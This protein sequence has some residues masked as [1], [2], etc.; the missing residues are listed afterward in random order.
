MTAVVVSNLLWYGNRPRELFFPERWDVEVLEPPGFRKAAI[1]EKEISRAFNEPIG[2]KPLADLASGA[3]EVVIGFDDITRPTPVRTVLPFVLSE[4]ALAG[5]RTDSIRFIPALG[6]HGAMTNIEFRKKLGDDVVRNYP[7]Y[8]HNPYENCDYLGDSTSG[9]P[10]YINREFMSCELKI[11]IGCI[12]PHV[13]AGFGGGGKL[14]LPGLAGHQTIKFFHGDLMQRDIGS[15]GLGKFEGNVMVDAIQEVVRMSGLDIKIDTL[16]NA[17]GEITD[18]FVGDPVEACK[19][20]VEVAKGHY[21]TRM[22]PNKD[23]V[24]VNAYAKYNEMAICMMMALSTANLAGSTIVLLVDAPEGQ[25]CHYLMRSFG[26]E[27]GGCEYAKRGPLPESLKVIVCSA[28]PDKTMC[29]LFAP[30]EGVTV[31]NNWE[32]T[33]SLLEADYPGSAAV[34]VIPDGTM[35]YFQ[36]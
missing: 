17:R 11:G 13:H 7:V 28:Y 21:A 22:S 31:T 9:I 30:A 25:V 2:C 4:L 27:Y 12:T 33:L 15:T 6:M 32:E 36:T 20:G 8:N 14:V 3:K 34:A 35:Q 5:I 1:D 19:A 16:I 26:K 23:I 10:V 29:D 24:V 18:L